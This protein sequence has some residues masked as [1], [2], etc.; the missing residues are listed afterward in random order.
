[1]GGGDEGGVSGWTT[2]RKR[3]ALV[4]GILQK[5]GYNRKS[6]TPNARQYSCDAKDLR[7]TRALPPNHT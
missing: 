6:A 2:H 7:G 1:L 4:M 5:E 3:Q